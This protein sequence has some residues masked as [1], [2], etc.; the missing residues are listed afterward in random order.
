M[1]TINKAMPAFVVPESQT[2]VS[3]QTLADI[4]LP[5]GY[6]FVD[7]DQTL[8]VGENT[9][10][11]NYNPDADNYETVQGNM[12]VV[13]ENA[14]KTG[15]H[16]IRNANGKGVKKYLEN[17]ILIIEVEGVKYDVTGRIIK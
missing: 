6:S 14:I 10:A 8:E 7:A 1:F 9:V 2:I 3:T 15:V 4:I 16:N 13:V 5:A 17:G 12:I 11:L